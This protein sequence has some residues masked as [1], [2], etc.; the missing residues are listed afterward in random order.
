MAMGMAA[1]TALQSVRRATGGGRT[2]WAAVL[3]HRGLST[4]AAPPLTA[5]SEEETMFKDTGAN[6]FLA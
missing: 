3:G 5:L 4:E 2:R 1:R 6:G